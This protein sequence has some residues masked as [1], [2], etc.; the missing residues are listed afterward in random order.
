M[1]TGEV[2]SLV[3]LNAVIDS[4]LGL[5]IGLWLVAKRAGRMARRDWTAWLESEEALP[6]LDRVA[7]RTAAKMEP[8]LSA[9]EERLAQPVQIDFSQVVEQ[10]RG[11]VIDEVARLRAFID[12]KVGWFKK[13]GKGVGEAVAEGAGDLALREAGIDGEG[14]EIL[15]EL[16][17]L[18]SDRDWTE[19]HRAAAFGLRLLK[20]QLSQ[21]GGTLSLTRGGSYKPGLPGK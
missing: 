2:L 21:D 6:Y 15:G 17:R 1:D 11:P 10:V 14:S 7:D 4:I 13:V 3:T 19:E 12:G 18:L 9:F 5:V 16:D 20:R 8:R